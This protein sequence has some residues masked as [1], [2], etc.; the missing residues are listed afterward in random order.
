[1]SPAT[2]F[3]TGW[4]LAN[5]ASLNRRER[6]LVT[7]AG[8]VPDIWGWRHRRGPHSAL[9]PSTGVVFNLPSC[10]THPGFLPGRRRRLPAGRETKMED[11]AIDI[12]QFSPALARGFAR[13]SWPG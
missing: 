3:L 8:V 10:F 1:M 4:V 12:P 5:T 11:C 7:L 13:S 2:H 6:A 9:A